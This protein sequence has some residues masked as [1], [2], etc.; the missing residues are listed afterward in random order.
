M[1]LE[2]IER[3][4][5]NIHQKKGNAKGKQKVSRKHP[6]RNVDISSFETKVKSSN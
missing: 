1:R 4:A 6:Y 3:L 2:P 5:I